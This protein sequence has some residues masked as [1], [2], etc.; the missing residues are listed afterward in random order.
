MNKETRAALINSPRF[1][2]ATHKSVVGG[3]AA[4]E[5]LKMLIFP[6]VTIWMSV[7]LTIGVSSLVAAVASYFVLHR[8]TLRL[9]TAVRDLREHEGGEA[10]L[11]EEGHLLRTLLDNLPDPIY[12]KDREGHFTRINK[13][14]AKLFGLA[15][16]AQAVGKSDFDFFIAEHAQESYNDEQQIIV[17]GQPLVDKEERETWQDGRVTWVS[18]TKIPLR[19]AHGDI[20]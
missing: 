6:H 16:P 2:I 9:G 8:R 13:A 5:G 7:L 19:D 20:T 10:A 11:V 18:T 4:Y 17:T 14:H 1:P 15:D 12:F 3:M